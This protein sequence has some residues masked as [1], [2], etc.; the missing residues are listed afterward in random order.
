M[1]K[2]L[3]L[4]FGL[5]MTAIAVVAYT[6]MTPGGDDVVVAGE[7]VD[8]ETFAR[9]G[10]AGTN[11]TSYQRTVEYVDPD[12]GTSYEIIDQIGGSENSRIGDQMSVAFPADEPSNGRTVNPGAAVFVAGMLGI[13]GLGAT[14]VG[15]RALF[16]S[17]E[18]TPD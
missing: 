13:L 5:F 17:S 7:V 11:R 12:T 15:L 4:L 1:M 14:F 2:S 18:E 16:F 9:R 8:I 6:Q 3:V 10:G